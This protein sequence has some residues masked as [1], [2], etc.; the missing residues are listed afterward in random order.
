MFDW[1]KRAAIPAAAV[2]F[3]AFGSAARAEEIQY[4]TSGA[5]TGTG[6]LG[7]VGTASLTGSRSSNESDTTVGDG[8]GATITFNNNSDED[9]LV[10]PPLLS[11]GVNY[12]SF[13][14]GGTAP[15]LGT[16][17]TNG[18]T[19]SIFQVLPTSG[20]GSLVATISGTVVGS[21]G[22]YGDNVTVT[23]NP[24]TIYIPA[25]NPTV[26]YEVQNIGPGT[27][28]P[29]LA[30]SGPTSLDGTATPVPLPAT[31]G[32][33]L[34]LLLGLGVVGYVFRKRLPVV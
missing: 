27:T 3:L 22:L 8:S 10:V 19:L 17:F 21:V 15:L 5:F 32:T 4:Y 26:L 14:I 7:T 18:F 12:G 6:A 31:A 25:G 29:A 2:A 23:F 28:E 30:A 13:T 16:N 11:T 34:S 9:V 24:D 20:T 1:L 33:S